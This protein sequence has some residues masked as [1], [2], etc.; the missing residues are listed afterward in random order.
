MSLAK[1]N[2]ILI[3]SLFMI[4]TTFVIISYT[5]STNNYITNINTNNISI[6]MRMNSKDDHVSTTINDTNDDNASTINDA[7]D[8]NATLND[9]LSP[10]KGNY[11]NIS[12][13]N[14]NSNI[15]IFQIGFNKCGTRSI[16]SFF[17]EINNITSMHAWIKLTKQMRKNYDTN[18]SLLT[19]V[20]DNILYCD[21]DTFAT[22]D[23]MHDLMVYN[24]CLKSETF[25][26]RSTKCGY[27]FTMLDQQYKDSKFILNIRDVNLWIKSKFL[28]LYCVKRY[29]LYFIKSQNMGKRQFIFAMKYL[30]YQYICDVLHYFKERPNDLLI[31]DIEKDKPIEIIN[32]LNGILEFKDGHDHDTLPR[33]HNTT[34]E[35][36]AYSFFKNRAN[37]KM[38]D[39]YQ[40]LGNMRSK[41]F[42][43]G[44][45]QR[46][47]MRGMNRAKSIWKTIT[48]DNDIIFNENRNEKDV[49]LNVCNKNRHD[50]IDWIFEDTFRHLE[51]IEKVNI[52]KFR[53]K[54]K[55]GLRDHFMFGT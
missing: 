7:M 19:N 14:K 13:E 15:K 11:D 36:M 1:F 21:F 12:I 23:N 45:H 32:F 20:P 43:R 55:S 44:S 17:K 48:N 26:L 42:R 18:T 49:I 5:A 51:G 28:C 46:I 29:G 4:F 39:K 22:K 34:N 50:M 10:M 25:E 6:N 47:K 38:E 54:K 27:W 52:W 33:K 3:I 40:G 30:W 2:I 41:Q 53:E 9:T 8:I 24:K 31:F 37:K 16:Y 35:V